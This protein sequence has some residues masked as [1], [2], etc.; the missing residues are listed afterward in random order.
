MSPGSKG[1]P[2]LFA[3]EALPTVME[4]PLLDC[5]NDRQG[6]LGSVTHL[7]GH[8]ARGHI[9]FCLSIHGNGLYVHE[10]HGLAC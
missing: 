8:V 5:Q 2:V 6:D 9:Q 7:E 4:T 1:D 10:Q 3:V